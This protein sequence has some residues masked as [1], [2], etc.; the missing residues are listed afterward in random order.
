MTIENAGDGFVSKSTSDIT[1]VSHPRGRV[2]T[3]L[4]REG[5]GQKSDLQEEVRLRLKIFAKPD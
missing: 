1:T 3:I 2:K 4:S 5:K